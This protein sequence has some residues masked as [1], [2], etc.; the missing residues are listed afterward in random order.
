VGLDFPILL[1]HGVQMFL[2]HL[3]SYNSSRANYTTHDMLCQ[4]K[5]WVLTLKTKNLARVELVH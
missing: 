5:I 3:A 4:G 1:F 2:S